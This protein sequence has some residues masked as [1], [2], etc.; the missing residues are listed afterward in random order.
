MGFIRG[1]GC[2]EYIKAWSFELRRKYLCSILYIER[3]SRDRPLNQFFVYGRLWDGFGTSESISSTRLDLI[4]WKDHLEVRIVSIMLCAIFFYWCVRSVPQHK[5]G[6]LSNSSN[7]V[8]TTKHKNNKN[9]RYT[10]LLKSK[11]FKGVKY[12]CVDVRR[13]QGSLAICSISQLWPRLRDS[14]LKN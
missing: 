6:A 12:A 13:A 7:L 1:Y 4:M 5:C 3:D 2:G 8:T 14:S 11:T 10:Y 9:H